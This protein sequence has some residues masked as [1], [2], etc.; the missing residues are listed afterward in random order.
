MTNLNTT[1]IRAY[2]KYC[3]L[4]EIK[5][6]SEAIFIMYTEKGLPPDSAMDV[7]VQEKKLELEQK[8]AVVANFLGMLT[9]HKQAGGLSAD[10]L[11]KLQVKNL[12]MVESLAN[13][14]TFD[15]N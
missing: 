6:M 2:A 3:H 5:S 11:K 13:T 12:R 14:G 4:P 8:I 9:R 1:I 7:L 15:Y 10:G